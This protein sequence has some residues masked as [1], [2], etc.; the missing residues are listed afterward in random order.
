[1]DSFPGGYNHSSSQ[2]DIFRY[3]LLVS[4]GAAVGKIKF[5][6]LLRAH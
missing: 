3:D 1:M 6:G 5:K 2:G 4:G